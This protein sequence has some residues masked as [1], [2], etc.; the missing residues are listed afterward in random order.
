M[1]GRNDQLQPLLAR[2][3]L[4]RIHGGDWQ[5]LPSLWLLQL[6]LREIKVPTCLLSSL[7]LSV[8]FSFLIIQYN[9]QTWYLFP[10]F[11]FMMH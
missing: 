5:V 7:S 2:W 9:L 3:C 6:N 1:P 8:S 4:S 10:S 11:S